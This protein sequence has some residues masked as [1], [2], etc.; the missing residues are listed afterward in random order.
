M[1]N[2]QSESTYN[3]LLLEA[4]D[5]IMPPF[6]FHE[7]WPT[8]LGGQSYV[9]IDNEIGSST[10]SKCSWTILVG[11]GQVGRK[12]RRKVQDEVAVATP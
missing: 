2:L 12:L 10:I 11:T 8:G 4:K 7:L 3:V 6:H 5:R 9:N 1:L